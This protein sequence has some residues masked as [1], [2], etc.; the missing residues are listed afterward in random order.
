ME[1]ASQLLDNKDLRVLSELDGN[2][3]SPLSAIAK[4]TKLS[5]DIVSYRIH[6]LEQNKVILSYYPIIDGAKIGYTMF[7]V[8][9]KLCDVSKEA[10]II[11]YAKQTPSIGWVIKTYG[12]WDLWLVIWSHT[13]GSFEKTYDDLIFRFSSAIESRSVSPVFEIEH[14]RHDYLYGTPREGRGLMIGDDSALLAID[15]SDLGI[16]RHLSTSGRTPTALIADKLGVSPNTVKT[17]I[18]RMI[19]QKI[20]VGFKTKVNTTLLGYDHFKVFLELRSVTKERLMAL[21]QT[22]KINPSVI[23]ITKAIGFADIEFEVIVR[24]KNELYEYLRHLTVQ[25]SDTV[26]NHKSLLFYE[27]PKI[28]Y[29]A[30]G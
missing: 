27:E 18:G 14:F 23:Y 20:I 2:A 13:L 7:R 29:A 3:R 16:L 21:L 19:S 30:F 4:K 12:E 1:M 8:F 28:N 9:L 24:G 10:Q 5:K 6:Q 26:K 17:R 25:F 22:L 15:E 11:E